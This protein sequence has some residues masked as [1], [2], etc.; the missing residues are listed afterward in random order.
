MGRSRR[1]R[2][3]KEPVRLVIESLSHEGRGVARVDGK[4]VFVHGAL[5][6]EEVICRYVRSHRRYDEATVEEVVSASADRVEPKCAHFG[7]CGGCSLQHMSHE[8]QIRIKQA[9]LLENLEHLGRVIPKQV[10]PPLTGPV[11]NY[12]YK[13]RLAVKN[14]PA[15]GRVL[16]G[17][18]EKFSHYV[19]V[20]E[21]CPVLVERVGE[22]LSLLSQMIEKLS[23]PDQIPQIEVAVGDQSNSL[24]FRHLKPLTD[25]DKTI[26]S[27]F[28][29]DYDFQIYLQ[30]GGP[31]TVSLL[32]PEKAA[33]SYR[34]DEFNVAL[35][36]E[37][38][39]FTQINPQINRRM[40]PLA[41]SLLDLKP[42][43]RVLDL[44][45]G[46]GNFTLPIATRV[47]NVI[48]VEGEQAL[49]DRAQLNAQANGISNAVFYAADLTKDHSDK[50][51]LKTPFDAVLLDPPRSGALEVIPHVAALGASRIVYVSCHPATLAR[52]AGILVHEHGYELKKAGIMDMFPHTAHVESIALFEKVS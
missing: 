23:I 40:V 48:G 24:V 45:C 12:R 31:Q 4:A 3:P 37:P 35:H 50:E 36:F 16:V 8:A 5:P 32:F 51:W 1:R 26:L 18:R 14:V 46:L 13:A 41:I 52:D 44:F 43:D 7:V 27:Q 6:G 11:W 33:L 34:F 15:K 22:R 39:D 49:V 28:G 47:N 29:R 25:D 42:D 21:A 17:F 30:S 2:L 19:A 9:H 20:V 10:L 38:A